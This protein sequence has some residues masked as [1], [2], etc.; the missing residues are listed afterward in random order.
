MAD[1]GRIKKMIFR[2]KIR[3]IVSCQRKT[4]CRLLLHF[5]RKQGNLWHGWRQKAGRSK[6]SSA[7]AL[8]RPPPRNF[9]NNVCKVSLLLGQIDI[10]FECIAEKSAHSSAR[11]DRHRTDTPDTPPQPDHCCFFY[12]AAAG[13]T[14]YY[15]VIN[16]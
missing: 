15:L 6:D 13:D 16:S 3:Q 8:S 5:E 12:C 2:R 4:S 1:T 14:Q 10:G 9:C 7:F 11:H